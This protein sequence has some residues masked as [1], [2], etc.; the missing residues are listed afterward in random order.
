MRK[1][2]TKSRLYRPSADGGIDPAYQV[3]AEG[4]GASQLTVVT[5]GPKR[6]TLYTAAHGVDE[7]RLYELEA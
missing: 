7:V 1:F 6:A 2:T 4:I 5:R 3:L